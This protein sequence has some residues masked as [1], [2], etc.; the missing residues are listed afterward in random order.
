MIIRSKKRDY[1][2]GAVGF[3]I[4]KG[5]VYERTEVRI[6][7]P[8]YVKMPAED[9][10]KRKVVTDAVDK[11][12]EATKRIRHPGFD[13]MAVGFCGKIY[14]GLM[15]GHPHISM[16]Y[17][18]P[19]PPKSDGR[20]YWVEKDF[21]PNDLTSRTPV[22]F[23]D[24]KQY[25]YTAEQWL[26]ENSK[27]RVFDNLDTF[28]ALDAPV[29]VLF[30]RDLYINPCLQTYGFQRMMD[31]ITAFQEVSMFVSG[32]LATAKQQPIPHTPDRLMAAAKGFD[33][34][35]FR[36]GPSKRKSS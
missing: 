23:Y 4:D 28:L 36:K 15:P 35:S 24:P 21:A 8:L 25:T 1:Y 2:D 34:H 14:L 32:V 16:D 22:H 9:K 19:K 5:V 18:R 11:C 20:A 33:E 13:E 3:G 7:D 17:L 12:I 31:S 26:A 27:T 29:W 30:G 10:I 6:D